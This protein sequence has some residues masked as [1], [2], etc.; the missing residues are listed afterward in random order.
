MSS[1]TSVKVFGVSV[2]L[3]VGT[4]YFVLWRRRARGGVSYGERAW[5]PIR[6][7]VL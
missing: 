6:P 3:C 1:E 7:H 4:C 2:P 5:R